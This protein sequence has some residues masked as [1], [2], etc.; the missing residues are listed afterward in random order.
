MKR[1]MERETEEMD[2]L[3]YGGGQR[4]KNGER[5][6]AIGSVIW[7]QTREIKRGKGWCPFTNNSEFLSS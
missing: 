2:L 4:E 5:K 3:E 1:K 6:W 7:T